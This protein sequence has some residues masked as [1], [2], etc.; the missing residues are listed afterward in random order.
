MLKY[1]MANREKGILSVINILYCEGITFPGESS[2]KCGIG[3]LNPE[4]EEV[5]SIESGFMVLTGIWLSKYINGVLGEQSRKGGA[6]A[7]KLA[8][9]MNQLSTVPPCPVT[10]ANRL[11]TP[12]FVPEFSEEK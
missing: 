5:C 3:L 4:G 8:T 2:K 9:N 11:A 12:I 1:F 10:N 7:K 6:H